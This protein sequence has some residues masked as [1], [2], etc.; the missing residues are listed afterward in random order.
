MHHAHFAAVLLQQSHLTQGV[1][2]PR[3]RVLAQDGG[4]LVERAGG[5]G[6]GPGGV[7]QEAGGRWFAFPEVDRRLDVGPGEALGVQHIGH[8]HGDAA[9]VEGDGAAEVLAAGGLQ[10]AQVRQV[11]RDGRRSAAEPHRAPFPDLP[12]RR[13]GQGAYRGASHAGVVGRVGGRVDPVEERLELLL[14]PGPGRRPGGDQ[15]GQLDALVVGGPAQPVRDA[16]GEFGERGDVVHDEQD[17]LCEGVHAGPGGVQRD[18][19]VEVDDQP[20]LPVGEPGR[21]QADPALAGA[22]R[23]GEHHTERRLDVA[24]EFTELFEDARGGRGVPRRGVH[25]GQRVPGEHRLVPCQGRH[26]PVVQDQVAA[27]GVPAVRRRGARF[28]AYAFLAQQLAPAGVVDG[29]QVGGVVRADAHRGHVLAEH[30][31]HQPAVP[32]DDGR[33]GHPPPRAVAAGVGVGCA[34]EFQAQGLGP[35]P[36]GG[37]DPA[38]HVLPAPVLDSGEIVDDEGV[39]GVAERVGAHPA[40]RVAVHPAQV[41]GLHLG[42]RCRLEPQ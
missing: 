1:D 17:A 31:D 9:R 23:A 27:G 25:E 30:P 8:P 24:G 13:A 16:S 2:A 42:G 5:C 18:V 14:V 37:D 10:T 29:R 41:H 39:Y 20:A 22:R 21:L 7:R 36:G 35:S 33:T 19:V 6:S 28:G 4:Q 32:G 3:R 26:V 12:Y 15:Y 38:G 34:V 11:E 40:G